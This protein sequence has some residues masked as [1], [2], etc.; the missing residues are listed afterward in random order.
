M[1]NVRKTKRTGRIEDLEPQHCEDIKGIVAPEIGPKSFVTSENQ[2]TGPTSSSS[3]EDT[4]LTARRITI[5]Q[6]TPMV[7][8]E[9]HLGFSAV[10]IASHVRNGYAVFFC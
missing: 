3:K 9:S 5:E 6:T 1:F 10:V 7:L 8:I 2:D 4:T